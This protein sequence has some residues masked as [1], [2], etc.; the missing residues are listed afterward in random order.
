MLIRR[1]QFFLLSALFACL[2]AVSCSI[3]IPGLASSKT[4][5]PTRPTARP[6][7]TTVTPTP[8][9]GPVSG[10]TEKVN[11]DEFSPPGIGRDLVIMNCD[12][13]HSWICTLRGQRTLD[14]WMAVELNHKARRWVELSD[15]DW[16]VLF[17]Y[18]ERNFNDEKP[19][20]NFPP[21]FQQ[22]GCTHSSL[23]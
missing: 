19:V 12:Y 13:C 21:V 8:S 10:Y 15:E 17:L 11:L 7:R 1:T 18:L 4:A 23:R 22:A 20:P 3:S 6:V 14:H 16:D 2:L 9:V 5:T